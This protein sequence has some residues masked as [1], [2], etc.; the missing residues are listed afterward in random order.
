MKTLLNLFIWCLVGFV[1]KQF[2][3][4]VPVSIGIALMLIFIVPFSDTCENMSEKDSWGFALIKFFHNTYSEIITAFFSVSLGLCWGLIYTVVYS[5]FVEDIKDMF[6][7]NLISDNR[8]I[9]RKGSLVA[10]ALVL[11]HIAVLGIDSTTTAI[12]VDI[13]A[14][15]PAI[16]FLSYLVA[17]ICNAVP[18]AAFSAPIIILFIKDTDDKNT[19]ELLQAIGCEFAKR[20]GDSIGGKPYKLFNEIKPYTK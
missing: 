4:Y 3:W 7:D 13:T 9:F 12:I 16:P 20:M 1:L 18:T 6:S 19:W 8:K 2:G 11:I 14:A 5:L 17:A 10:L 15:L